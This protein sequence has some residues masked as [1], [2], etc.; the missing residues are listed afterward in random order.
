MAEAVNASRGIPV[1]G[2]SQD[3]T[4]ADRGPAGAYQL[5][6]RFS[7]D[8]AHRLSGLPA[9]H[10]C[11]RVHGHTYTV[12]VVVGAEELSGPGFVTDFGELGALGA[13]IEEQFDHRDLVE[14]LDVEPTSERI[15]AHLADWFT[16]NVEPGIPGRLVA[17][18]VSETPSTWAEYRV[19]AS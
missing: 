6:K 1:P 8:A 13:Y 16:R 4:N 12:E 14:V 17:V 15:A 9:G 7:F 5:G 3:D 2:P 11:G 10:K 18:R 19:A